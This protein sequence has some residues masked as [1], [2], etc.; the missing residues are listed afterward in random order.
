MHE[1]IQYI[2]HRQT[3][4]RGTL[5]GSLC[6]LDP[7]A[8]LVACAA[9]VDATVTVVG[10][11]GR[12]EIAFRGFSRRLH[13]AGDR[14]GRTADRGALSRL[15]AGPRLRLRRI[16]A[17]ARRLRHRVG[18][19]AAR[20]GRTRAGS[21]ALSV[22]I[23]GMRPGAGARARG[24]EGARRPSRRRALFRDACEIC[25]KLEA[26]EDVHAPA[27]YRQHLAAVLSRRALEKALRDCRVKPAARPLERVRVRPNALNFLLGRIFCGEPVPTSPE[28]DLEDPM[29]E[30]RKIRSP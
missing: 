18:G 8:E 14:A 21:R 20:D 15:G 25:R 10:P 27:S 11:K 2:G 16:R 1:A 19:G 30:T 12:R 3:R 24:R 29:G 4:N 22:T 6:H 26:I 13:D 7:S 28:N 23:G 17:P 9:T 5:G